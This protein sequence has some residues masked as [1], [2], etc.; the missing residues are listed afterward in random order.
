M[1]VV[2]SSDFN[3]RLDKYLS[4]NTELSRTLISKMIDDEFILVNNKKTKSNYKVKQNDLITINEDYKVETDIMPEKIDLD[5]VYEDNDIMII[6]KPS[7]M[8]VHPGN[9]NYSGTLVNG[10][11][12]YTNSLSDINGENRPGIVHRIDKDTSGLIMVAKNNKSHEILSE[13][14]QNKTIT[15]NYIALIKGELNTNSATI[16]APIGR[17]ET[18]RKKMAVTAKN[19]KNAITH[20]TVLKRYKGYTLVKLKLDTGR[21]HQIRVHMAYIG[22][23]VYNDPVYTNDKCSDFGQ[24][25]HSYSMDFIHPIT[26]KEM[27]FEVELPEYFKKHLEILEE[28]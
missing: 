4:N 3:E 6:N 15:R 18:D 8:V 28:K 5:I 10:L 12:Y 11:M 1:E 26:N 13:Y 20:L 27:H 25:L 14:F 23:P 22:H 9:G 19:S 17:S 24:F 16:D 21:T 2:V 7:G